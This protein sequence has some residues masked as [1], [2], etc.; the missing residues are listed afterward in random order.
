MRLKEWLQEN[1]RR[2]TARNEL[3]LKLFFGANAP[4][5]DNI[6][7]LYHAKKELIVQLKTYEIIK[8]KL[9]TDNAESSNLNYWLITL[10]YG[11]QHAKCT[12]KWCET[13][14]KKLNKAK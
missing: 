11:I 4:I 9:V 14:L 8:K 1:V 6:H 10:D 7:H 5:E 12:L 13:S 3:L 2:S